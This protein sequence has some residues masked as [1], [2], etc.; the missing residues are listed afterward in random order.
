MRSIRN[1]YSFRNQSFTSVP[2]LTPTENPKGGVVI[3]ESWEILVPASDSRLVSYFT[4]DLSRFFLDAF[5]FSPRIRT[6]SE[7]GPIEGY[8]R[9]I[10]LAWEEVLETGHVGSDMAAAF[11]VSITPS[12]VAVVGKT[13]RGTAQGVYYLEDCMRLSGTPTLCEE[14]GEHAPL[15]SPRM[16]HSGTEL[17]TFPD[18]YLAACAHAGMDAIIIY[19]GHPDSHLHGFPDPDAL[20][21]G[22]GRGYCDFANLAW[23]AE[24]YGLDVYVYSQLICDRHPSDPD[25]YE[26]YDATFGRIFREAPALRGLI[27]VGESF[28]FPSKD[29]RTSGIRSQLKPKEDRRPSPGRFPSSDYPEMLSLVRDVVR[30]YTPDA[31]IVF[32]SYNFGWT[33]KEDRL[34]LIERLPRDIS[35]LV[36]LEVWG[37]HTAEDGRRYSIADYS[38]AVPGPSHIFTEEAEKAHACGLRLY[39]MANTGGRTWDSG[40]APY[41]PAPNA[42]MARYAVLREARESYG[43]CGLMENH[44]YGWM[45]SF[46]TLLA[47]NA[48]SAGGREDGDMLTAIARRDFGRAAT[49]ALSGWAHVS[50]G[51][52]RIIPSVID[53]YGPY[54]AGPAYPLLFT[55]TA[56]ELKIPKA[57]W[58]WHP[59]GGIW[60]PVYPDEIFPDIDNSL[61]RLSRLTEAAALFDRG[62]SLLEAARDEGG[63]ALGSEP[64][65]G[66][67]V[68][69]YLAA[70]LHTAR[71][72]MRWNLAKKLLFALREGGE[73]PRRDELFAA[74]GL[75]D[76]TPTALAALLRADAEEE[77]ACVEAGLAAYREDSAIGFEAS[78][79][80]VF[81]E[82]MAA[83]KL[84]ELDR[85][86][87]LLD[88][89]MKE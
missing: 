37:K 29:P 42:W 59:A 61:L 87:T 9:K 15:F 5:G 26:Y 25:A 43:L 45:P 76:E 46:L 31:D 18:D 30:A 32:W 27:L 11:T 36:T 58:A 51:M 17:D 85:S 60:K 10:V 77:R 21:P 68:V 41:I 88:D 28:E 49:A 13:E 47:K 38:I 7:K 2:R 56:A 70:S 1:D 62:L 20:W 50:Q 57:P 6:L 3:D 81:N 79:E 55:Q 72:V 63:V 69:R 52:A 33:P 39:T 65:R 83:W 54:R 19:A 16:T 82:E 78:M 84:S 74:L 64:S 75:T 48:L 35:Y 34:A 53:Q 12:S 40:G 24:G 4:N 89:Y 67:A 71:H 44:H 14:A 22:S 80:Y 8:S 86:L 23:R 66:I 73:I